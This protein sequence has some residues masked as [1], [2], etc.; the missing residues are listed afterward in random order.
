MKYALALLTLFLVGCGTSEAQRAQ[1]ALEAKRAK[2]LQ[3]CDDMIASCKANDAELQRL[4]D[5]KLNELKALGKPIPEN[6]D[7]IYP[8][9]TARMRN[10]A[11]EQAEWAARKQTILDAAKGP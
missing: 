10:S 3:E 11:K 9:Y 8:R 1:S 7:D 2:M 5:D 6:K 4:Y